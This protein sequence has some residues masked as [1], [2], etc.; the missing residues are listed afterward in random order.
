MAGW[1]GFGWLGCG[2]AVA[3]WLGFGWLGFGWLNFRVRH[4]LNQILRVLDLVRHLL[5][6][7]RMLDAVAR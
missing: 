3:G 2:W 5:R 6:A 4:V 7:L 1:L